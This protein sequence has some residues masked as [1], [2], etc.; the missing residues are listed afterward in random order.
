MDCKVV[1]NYVITPVVLGKGSFGT[2]YRGYMKNNK[3]YIK[4]LFALSSENAITSISNFKKLQKDG[5]DFSF[6]VNYEELY[7]QNKDVNSN[8]LKAFIKADY[9]KDA[10]LACGFDFEKG[11]V[12][13]VMD[14]YFSKELAAIYKKYSNDNIDESLVQRIPSKD[15]DVLVAYNLKP[16]MIEDFLKEFKLDGLA[17]LG[18]IAL[19]IDM[20]GVLAAFKGD[21]VFAL[22]DIKAKP[23][24]TVSSP[25]M[26]TSDFPDFNI[27]VGDRITMILKEYMSIRGRSKSF[28]SSIFASGYQCFEDIAVAFVLHDFKSIKPMLH[29]IVWSDNDARLIPLADL[30]LKSGI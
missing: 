24:D 10:A 4:E 3:N 8:E 26:Y 27:S 23:K 13:M 5:H 17:N 29:D 25:L 6:W 2:V 15:I 14:Y 7:K 20:E 21:I 22:S 16:K 12:D 19:G 11:A 9:F 30:A 18:L 1:Q 28:I